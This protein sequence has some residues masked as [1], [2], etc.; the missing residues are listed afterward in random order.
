MSE[1]VEFGEFVTAGVALMADRDRNSWALGDLARQFEIKLGRPD[2]PAA[3]TLS[4]LAA[5]WNVSTQRVSEWRHVAAFY[6]DPVRSSV[7][8]PWEMWNMARRASQG[9]L[10]NALELL[11]TARSLHLTVA[12]FRRYLKGWYFEGRVETHDLPP[13]LQTLLPGGTRAVWVVMKRYE[14]GQ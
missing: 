7:D 4:D 12:S 1:P 14:E 11:A 8:C 5:A 2:D 9:S 6:P 13:Y 10:S 3:P